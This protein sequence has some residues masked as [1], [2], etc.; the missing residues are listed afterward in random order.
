MLPH[1]LRL[2]YQSLFFSDSGDNEHWNLVEAADKISAYIKCIEE[3][4]A[5]NSEFKQAAEALKKVITD[6]NFAEMNYFMETY[7]PSFSLSLDELE[8]RATPNE[9]VAPEKSVE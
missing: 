7:I 6:L 5:G 8:F 9:S 2:D 1:E 4:N 3:L